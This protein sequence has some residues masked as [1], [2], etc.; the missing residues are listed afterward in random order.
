MSQVELHGVNERDEFV[1]RVKEAVRDSK[2]GSWILG[3]GWNNDLWGGALPMTW[4]VDDV[5]PQNPVW[6][7]RMDGHMGLADSPALKLAGVTNSSE[8]PNGGTIMRTSTGEPTGLLVDSAMQFILP[9]IPEVSVDECR[10]ALLKASNFALTRRVTTVVDMGRC[11]PGISVEFSWQDFSDV[12]Q[13]AGTSG[14]MRIRVCLFFPLEIWSR[15]HVRHLMTIALF[16]FEL[17]KTKVGLW[18]FFLWNS[19]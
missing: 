2:P 1:R 14:K 17:N 4:W 10:E 7:T 6:L 15:L 12:Y 9:C 11:Y 18:L 8:D 13:W 3:G 5:T 16:L 19:F